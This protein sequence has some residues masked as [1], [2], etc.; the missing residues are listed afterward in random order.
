MAS[1]CLFVNESKT[2]FMIF[3]RKERDHSTVIK[4]GKS[5]ICEVNE[6]KL[7]GVTFS[8]DL[9]WKR[10]IESL[11]EKLHNQIYLLRH[12]SHFFPH[13]TL[14]IVAEGLVTSHIRYCLPLFGR[15]RLSDWDP[16]KFGTGKTSGHP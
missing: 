13:S 3:S 9:K 12:L 7:L 5:H 16:K 8:S 10:H 4:V 2:T 1:N 14:K 15:I 11:T 6:Q